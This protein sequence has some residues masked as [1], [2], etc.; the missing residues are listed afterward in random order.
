M[1]QARRLRSGSVMIM[2]AVL[3]PVVLAVSAYSIN[4]VYMELSRTQLQ[5]TTDVA[6]RAAGRALAV[7]GEQAEARAAADRVIQLNSFDNRRFDLSS[8]DLRFGTSIR[9]DSTRYRFTE[10]GSKPNA[11][12]F[13]TSNELR[14]PMLFPTM[15]IPVDFRPVKSAICTQVELDIVLVIDRSGSMAYGCYEPAI[16]TSPPANAPPGWQFGMPVPEGSRWLDVVSSVSI[17]LQLLD[18]SVHSERVGLVTFSDKASKECSLTDDYSSAF[19]G[20]SNHT[21]RF[22]GG[23]TNIGDGIL[24]GAAIL[25]DKQCARDWASRVMVVLTDGNWTTGLDPSLCAN[26]AAAQNI[27]IYTLTFSEEAD[28]AKMQEVALI[29]NGCHIHATSPQELS[30]AFKSITTTLP[31][32]ITY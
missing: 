2:M 31:T 10:S 9:T 5:V 26:M 18:Q 19:Q 14:V 12:K 11:V 30:E 24:S 32:L 27:T 1:R 6:T 8:S 17:F 28:Q 15:G 25:S 16:G 4:V 21:V 7:T 20:L 3:L 29:G 22:K 13:D 23:A